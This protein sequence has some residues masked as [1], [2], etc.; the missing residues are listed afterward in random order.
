MNTYPLTDRDFTV[1]RFRVIFHNILYILFV[2]SICLTVAYQVFLNSSQLKARNWAGI[3]LPLFTGM[4]DPRIAILHEASAPVLFIG[5]LSLGAEWYSAYLDTKNSKAHGYAPGDL[6]AERVGCIHGSPACDTLTWYIMSVFA[7]SLCFFAELVV[8]IHVHHRE[9]WRDFFVGL[10]RRLLRC[11]EPSAAAASDA[12]EHGIYGHPTSDLNQDPTGPRSSRQIGV[13]PITFPRPAAI[14]SSS[15]V[16]VVPCFPLRQDAP[17]AAVSASTRDELSSVRCYQAP[18]P[19]Q[20]VDQIEVFEY[21]PTDNSRSLYEGEPVVYS[22]PAH[23]ETP[24]PVRGGLAN[25]VNM[26]GWNMY[27]DIP[28][29][30][31]T[32][33]PNHSRPRQ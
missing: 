12:E 9:Q 4:S 29:R 5:W 22:V 2:A 33:H 15:R 14:A 23:I 31:D 16:P 7:T 32:P 18:R 3:I 30:V 26:L 19:Q 10:F 13:L 6:Y 28:P 25:L 11:S 1:I 20:V 8:I 27:G 17:A 24:R 21:L